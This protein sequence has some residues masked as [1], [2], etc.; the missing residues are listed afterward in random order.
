MIELPDETAAE[1][2]VRR[3]RNLT[4]DYYAELAVSESGCAESP[5]TVGSSACPLFIHRAA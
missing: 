5:T 2:L 4:S 3:L 1:R